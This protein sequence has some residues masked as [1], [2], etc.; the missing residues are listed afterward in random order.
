MS[1]DLKKALG[2]VR[3]SGFR[4]GEAWT[5]AHEIAQAHEGE[6][7]FDAL[8]ALLHRIEGDDWNAVYWDRRAGTD[9]KGDGPEA[10]FKALERLA[11]GEPGDSAS[12]RDV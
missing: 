3:A 9:L 6:R 2:H 11:G 5:E 4:V 7:L 1:D 8:H 10:E 12:Q